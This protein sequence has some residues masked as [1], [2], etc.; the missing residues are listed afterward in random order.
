MLRTFAHTLAAAALLLAAPATHAQAQGGR[1]QVLIGF[2]VG[3]EPVRLASLTDRIAPPAVG[4]YLPIQLTSSLRV[5]PSLALA[6][7]SQ[8]TAAA[9]ASGPLSW[10]T[11]E[12]GV[13]G[14]LYVVPPSPLGIYLGGRLAL[15]FEAQKDVGG[16]AS[17]P[18][19]R[20]TATNL[21][22]AGVLGG[23]Y[24][25][26]RSFSVGAEAQLGLTFLGDRRIEAPNGV[27]TALSRDAALATNGIVYLRYF[28]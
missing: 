26:H 23:E 25:V 22:L 7:F 6:T 1:G 10:T 18:V 15:G 3:V 11:L 2:G 17:P 9:Q 4:L 21:T 19:T 12:L 5:E 27:T 16:G 13:A 24:F 28:F 8:G 14:H 20:T